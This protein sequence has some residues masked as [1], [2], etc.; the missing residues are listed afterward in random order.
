MPATTS[1][2]YFPWQAIDPRS[3]ARLIADLRSARPPVIVF[4]HSEAVNDRWVAGEYGA[5]LLQ[6]LGQ[7]YA[8]L[9][10]SSPVLSDVLVPRERLAAAQ[11]RVAALLGYTPAG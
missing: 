4:R 11:Q 10:P 3:Q 1:P 6:V 2:F 8:P 9:D 7:D 5:Q